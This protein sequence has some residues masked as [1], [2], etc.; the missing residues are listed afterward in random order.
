MQSIYSG[1]LKEVSRIR[2]EALQRAVSSQKH[3][4]A[5][6]LAKPKYIWLGPNLSTH[7]ESPKDSKRQTT[8]FTLTTKHQDN[9]DLLMPA[10]KPCLITTQDTTACGI[11]PLSSS[12]K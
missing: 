12:G 3:Y 4:F 5:K 6:H 1:N 7:L 10:Y 2:V 9:K 11:C 8:C